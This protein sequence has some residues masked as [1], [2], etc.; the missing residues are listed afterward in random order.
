MNDHVNHAYGDDSVVFSVQTP[1]LLMCGPPCALLD[2]AGLL[3][4]SEVC[5]GC[6]H[7]A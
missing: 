7:D 6:Q 4:R 1:V 5:S 2:T 3:P